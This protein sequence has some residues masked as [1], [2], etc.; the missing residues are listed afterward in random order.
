MNKRI[1]S[2]NDDFMGSKLVLNV[3]VFLIIQILNITDEML[4]WIFFTS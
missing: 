3:I 2:P 4:I 1:S